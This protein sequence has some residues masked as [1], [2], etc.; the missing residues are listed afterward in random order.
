MD[1]TLHN[2]ILSVISSYTKQTGLPC[3][4]CPTS[5]LS[6]DQQLG[7]S[8]SCQLCRLVQTSASGLAA[9]IKQ[10][11]AMVDASF[12]EYA[13]QLVTCHANLFEWVAPVFYKGQ[14]VGYFAA[15]FVFPDDIDFRAREHHHHICA[16]RFSLDPVSTQVAIDTQMSIAKASIPPL[17]DLLFSLVRLNI[18]SGRASRP[19]V[20]LSLP[21]RANFVMGE[22]AH[23]PPSPLP[24]A[25]PLSYYI[26]TESITK[27]ELSNFWKIVEVKA[28]N[29][30]MNTMSGHFAEARESFDQLMGLV[31]REKS[32]EQ[33]HAGA[34]MLFHIMTLKFYN[35]DTF[36]VRFYRLT[37]DVI[38]QLFSA[39]SIRE[40]QDIMDDALRSI[41]RFFNVNEGQPSLKTVSKP[42]ID[43]LEAHYADDIKLSDIEK[44]TYMS[45]TYASR[46]FKKETSLTIKSCLINIRMRHAQ[47]LILNSDMMIKD[48]AGA[49]GYTDIRGFYKMF[50]K[51]FG[52]TCSEMRRSR[53]P[54]P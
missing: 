42:I 40:I 30:F 5:N 21:A 6:P 53:S 49:V 48:V 47:D 52:I 16:Q 1:D 50:A 4:F 7:V 27:E 13:C 23:S 45:A 51:H 26:C 3:V 36:D 43:Y 2:G 31:Y 8:T 29:V 41:Y 17:V 19:P 9:C 54:R 18:P 10:R 15:G 11:K 24:D 34:E 46:L 33:A 37:Y 32:V 14:P 25:A 20:D 38:H 22:A 12:R 44:V 28:I 35:K 39:Q